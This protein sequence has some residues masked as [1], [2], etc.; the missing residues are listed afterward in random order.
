MDR[1]SAGPLAEYAERLLGYLPDLAAGLL[2][3]ALGF[4]VGWVV[5][6]IVV[7]ILILLR[8]DRLGGRIGW[9][10]AF[11]KGDIRATLYNAIG[12]AAMIVVVLVFLDNAL[13][14]MGLNVISRI[15]D[16]VVFYV[17][18]LVIAGFIL[19]VGFQVA[20][21]V[22]NRTGQVLEDE[23]LARARLVAKSLKAL[24]LSVTVVL[25]IWELDFA[26]DIVLWFFL[27]GFGAIAIAF[28]LG[29]G[30]GSARAMQ[31]AWEQ[32]F[33]KRKDE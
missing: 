12:T 26:R 8:L 21:S 1:Q 2:V 3:V 16:R 23:G 32:L 13:Q 22:G 9:R 29:V 14:I 25:A 27:I 11:G 20:R 15:L 10:T 6:R 19:L 33:K 17:P 28:A 18:N 4:A 7:R 24:I 30:I 5:K 31:R